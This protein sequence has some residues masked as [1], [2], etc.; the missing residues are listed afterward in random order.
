MIPL[1]C[2]AASARATSTASAVAARGAIGPRARCADSDMPSRYSITMHGAPSGRTSKSSTLT[3]FSCRIRLTTRASEK[4][5]SSSARSRVR[6]SE[7]TLMA[8]RAPMF[9]C[10]AR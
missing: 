10:T 3:M 9:G 7:S 6:S 8:T 1:S 4:K 2:A 5:R